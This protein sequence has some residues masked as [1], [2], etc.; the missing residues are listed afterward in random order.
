MIGAYMLFLI[1]VILT[2]L[3]VGTHAIGSFFILKNIP[4]M[5]LKP[6]CLIL[7]ISLSVLF[8][9]FLHVLDS[10]FFAWAYMILDGFKS[11]EI[12]QY[13]S[14][15]SYTT[16]GYGD[17]LLPTRLRMLGGYE[18]LLGCLMIGWSTAL[19]LRI[20]HSQTVTLPDV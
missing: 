3:V 9:L 16:I 13:F 7:K 17:V 19:L 14:I 12:A 15:V 2:I 4:I 6:I 1:T 10:F 5:R 11:A 20:L 18:G 8:I